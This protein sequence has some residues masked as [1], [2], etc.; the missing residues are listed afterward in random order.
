MDPMWELAAKGGVLG[1]CIL[2]IWLG[3]KREERTALTAKERE[4]RSAAAFKALNDQ[5]HETHVKTIE[6]LTLLNANT[7]QLHE[8]IKSRPCIDMPWNG[9][10]RRMKP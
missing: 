8:E 10:D 5:S 2:T 4:E 1:V 6:Q 9:T 3:W 7:R